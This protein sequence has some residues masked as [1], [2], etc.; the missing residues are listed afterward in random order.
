MSPHRRYGQTQCSHTRYGGVER[1]FLYL[2]CSMGSSPSG[3]PL[4]ASY[5]IDHISPAVTA[6]MRKKILFAS[7]SRRWH[8]KQGYRHEH[9]GW[10]SF[11]T[12][13]EG[14]AVRRVR[15]TEN[16]HDAVRVLRTT[17]SYQV[18]RLGLHKWVSNCIY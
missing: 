16:D 12:G 14:E 13:D 2:P 18:V 10:C 3:N 17:K 1:M 6:S 9:C 11:P 7:C 15:N 8:Q 5:T 4:A